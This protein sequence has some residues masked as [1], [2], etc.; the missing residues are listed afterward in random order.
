MNRRAFTLIELLVVIAII[1]ILAAILFPVFAQAKEAAKKTSDLSNV[2]QLSLG[3]VLYQN[4]S[5]GTYYPHVTERVAPTAVPDTAVDRF[6]YT[7]RGK[8]GPYVKSQQLFKSPG[9]KSWPTPVVNNWWN[10]D[11]GFNHNEANLTTD[12]FG[13][14]FNANAAWVAW[15]RDGGARGGADFGVNETV[16]ETSLAEPANFLVLAD[17][18]RADGSASRGGVYPQRY[19]GTAYNPVDGVINPAVAPPADVNRQQARIHAR[20]N[21]TGPNPWQGGA[22]IG[23]ADGHAKFVNTPDK[24]WRSYNDND[25]RR[26]P[27]R[28]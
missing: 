2:K 8:L 17:T 25:W 27:I 28:G 14:P 22:N 13:R 12:A 18:E 20:F 11:F 16:T 6:P 21:R 9:T 4:D 5:D 24:T 23:Y 1:A 7:I 3:T 19:V 15:Y 10:S 26:N